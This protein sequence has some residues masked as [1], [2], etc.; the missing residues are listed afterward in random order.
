MYS[1]VN[2]LGAILDGT[3]AECSMEAVALNPMAVLDAL[4]KIPSL[5]AFI[6]GH[7]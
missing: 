6:R 1:E 5:N 7:L 2:Y 4:L 3:F